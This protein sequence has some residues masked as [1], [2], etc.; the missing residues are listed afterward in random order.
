MALFVYVPFF[1]VL[2]KWTG[3]H[4]NVIATIKKMERVAERIDGEFYNPGTIGQIE[5]AKA[6]ALGQ[7]NVSRATLSGQIDRAFDKMEGNVDPYLDWYYS[8]SAEY[9][10]LAKLMTGTIEGY[11][12][13]KLSEYL[14][15]GEAF[16]KVSD[17]IATALAS[18][19]NVMAEY[20]R[21]TKA[22][23]DANRQL[24]PPGVEV[25][26]TKD[27]SSDN[28]LSLPAHLDVVAFER[29]VAGTGIAAGISAAI[30][31]KVASKGVFQAAAKALSKMVASKAAAI[32]GG[33][34]I[35]AAIGSVVPGVGTVAVGALGAVLGGIAIDGALLKLE[36][37]ISRQDFKTSRTRYFIPSAKPSTRSN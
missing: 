1:A 11:M 25:R 33:T 17:A 18:H 37:V 12:E 21:A 13:A 27:T 19:Q 15:Q 24:F 28:I 26:V 36:E 14:Q 2:E 23:M 31:A 4:P 20:Q 34:A 5:V 35:G 30:A 10:R 6:I 7:L 16:Q 9:V 8:L 32:L 3:D 22:I 29:R